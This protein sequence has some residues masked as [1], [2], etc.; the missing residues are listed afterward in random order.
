MASCPS[1]QRWPRPAQ[2]QASCLSGHRRRRW[3]TW[4]QARRS[5][6]RRDR[7]RA[8][9]SRAVRAAAAGRPRLAGALSAAA[10]GIGFPLLVKAAAGGGGRGMRRIDTP[11][12]LAA[13]A[14]SASREAAAAFGDGSVY[15]ERLV[16]NARHVEVQ[17]LGDASGSIVALGER[18]CSVQ[19]RH[20]KLVEEAPAPGLSAT[21]PGRAARA[22][23]AHRRRRRADQRR[24]GGVPARAERRVLVPGGQCPL[25]G[26][27]RRHRARDRHGHRAEQ[28]W[29]AAGRTLSPAVR[30]A[31]AEATRPSR[32][33]IEVRISA[34]DPAREFAPAPGA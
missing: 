34:E 33:A 11:A 28:L 15:L 26:R 24:D 22:G 17:L 12:E 16:E 29:I 7:R 21:T 27:A 30:G 31:A 1:N 13:G 5:S 8:D 18:D 19:R 2:R 10:D 14:A 32:H 3:R 23:G 9:S 20:Q 6:N 25:A 4:R